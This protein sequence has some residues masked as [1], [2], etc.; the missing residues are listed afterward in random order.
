M[1]RYIVQ[2]TA[3]TVYLSPTGQAVNGFQVTL[4]VPE[5][6]ETHFLTVPDLKAATVKSAADELVH[7]RELLENLGEE[8]AEDETE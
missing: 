3:P 8:T 7:Q 1:S 6:D 2:R 5:F 4:Y